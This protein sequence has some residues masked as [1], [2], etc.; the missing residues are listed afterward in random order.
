[1]WRNSSRPTA[2]SAPM[3]GMS[4]AFPST[5]TRPVQ[6]APTSAATFS[7]GAATPLPLVLG[8]PDSRLVPVVATGSIQR[9]VLLGIAGA[10][11]GGAKALKPAMRVVT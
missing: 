6:A 11:I 3:R 9:L 4:W 7:I 1:M 8:A 10:G 2:F 5:A